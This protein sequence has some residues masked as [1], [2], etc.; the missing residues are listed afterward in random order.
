MNSENKLT[1]SVSDTAISTY[2]RYLDAR[3]LNCPMPLLKAKQQLHHLDAGQLLF[4]QATDPGSWADFASYAELS[5]HELVF[6]KKLG[7]NFH[8]LLQKGE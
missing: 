2:D 1:A 3:G 4:I 8:F 5:K 7:D 6:R